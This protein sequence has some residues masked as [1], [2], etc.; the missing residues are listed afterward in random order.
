MIPR[1]SYAVFA[2]AG[3]PVAVSRCRV[4]QQLK[5]SLSLKDNHSIDGSQRTDVFAFRS[6][7]KSG[8]PACQCAPIGSAKIQT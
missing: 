4:V 5:R 2:V 1:R 8:I 7:M 3:I 6:E